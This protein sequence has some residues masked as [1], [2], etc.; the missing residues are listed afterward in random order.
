M[1]STS[2]NNLDPAD[3]GAVREQGIRMLDDMLNYLREIRNRP[4]WQPAPAEVREAF[5]EPLPQRPTDLPLIHEQF[6]RDILPYAVGNAHPGFMGWVHGGGTVV[7]MLAEMLAAGL[8]ANVGGR[9]QVPVEVERQVTRWVQEVFDFPESSTGL[10]VTGTSMANLIGVLVAR[11]AALGSNVRKNGLAGAHLTAYASTSVHSCVAKAMDMA[12]LGTQALRLI[13]VDAHFRMDIS[14]LQIAIEADRIAGFVPFLVIGTA[15]TVDVGA[16]D[17]LQRIADVAVR[18]NLWFHVD[19]ALGALARLAP[20]I[21]AYVRGI[22]RADSIAFDF[23]KWGQVPYD[24]GFI[25]V[26][27]GALHQATFANP[28][29][30]LARGAALAGGGSW[31]CDFGP[32]LSRGFRALKTWFTIKAYGAAQLGAV[33]DHTC[34]LARYMKER[35]ESTPELELMAPVA[36]NIVCFRYRCDNADRVNENLVAQLQL[37]GICAPSTTVINGQLTIR[38]AIVNHRTS[39]DDINALIETTCAL[40]QICAEQGITVVL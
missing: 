4:V 13:P 12:G 36:L 10:F 39:K 19:G 16:V 20:Q 35:I 33:I 5:T 3:W 8:N 31:P 27:D 25:L 38:A 23:H 11:T 18:H 34:V 40:G 6:M 7:G 17:D 24:A 30:Y 9:D 37:S 22:E 32:D 14:A 26:R 29:P 2:P 28:A 15:G 21:G 1:Y